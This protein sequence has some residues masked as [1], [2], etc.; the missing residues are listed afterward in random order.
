MKKIIFVASLIVASTAHAAPVTSLYLKTKGAPQSGII[1]NDDTSLL[2]LEKSDIKDKRHFDKTSCSY[3]RTVLTRL[4]EVK[5]GFSSSKNTNITMTAYEDL[6]K[7]D[8]DIDTLLALLKAGNGELSNRL[9]DDNTIDLIDIAQ[10]TSDE[11]LKFTVSSL[12]ET[13]HARCGF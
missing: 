3:R 12:I 6:L 2:V 9:D 10:N 11:S 4:H 7:A 1:I 13:M 5:K 8:K